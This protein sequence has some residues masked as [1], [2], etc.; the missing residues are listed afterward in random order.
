MAELGDAIRPFPPVAGRSAAFEQVSAQQ[1]RDGVIGGSL[2]AGE[3]VRELEYEPAPL[4]AVLV[5]A[6]RLSGKGALYR[7]LTRSAV[8][9]A[10]VVLIAVAPAPAAASPSASPATTGAA[11]GG[12]SFVRHLVPSWGFGQVVEAVGVGDLNGDHRP[13][14]VVAG[15]QYLLLY[16]KP[17]VRPE[18]VARGTFGAGAATVVRDVDGDRRPD[19]VTGQ[20][21]GSGRREEVWFTRTPRG[22]SRRVL[23]S[24]AYCHDL[25]FAPVGG[26]GPVDA[27]CVDQ[28]RDRIVLLTRAA[29]VTSPWSLGTIQDGVNAM[30][31]A[32]ADVDRDGR[33]DVVVGRSWYRNAGAGTWAR[34]PYTTLDS[35]AYPEFDDYAKVAVLDLN[36]DGR[37]DIVASLFAETPAGRL[38]AFL[39]PPDPRGSAWT[40][41]LLDQGPLFGVHSLAVAR[42][43]GCPRPELVI[44]ETNIGGW[45]F[46]AAPHPHI[47]L[48]R[49]MGAVGWSRTVVD[50][51]GAHDVQAADINGDGLPDLVG[52][53]E[54]T[55]LARPPRNGRVFWWQNVTPPPHGA[56]SCAG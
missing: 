54:N 24:D 38:Y 39:A 4:P 10:A 40:P 49:L 15:D 35:A 48:Y 5:A 20:T 12:P 55:N 17:T 3:P 31:A 16:A 52:H 27:V 2:R 41:V 32:L 25:V 19:I 37:P 8:A 53:E 50:S 30:G 14:I 45:D 26:R 36:G 28:H 1:D 29:A 56:S 46:G 18:L 22:W 11:P 42:F 9:I 13:D 47:D 43:D 51:I 6:R 33:L 44:A 34:Y 7:T 23:S 21:L